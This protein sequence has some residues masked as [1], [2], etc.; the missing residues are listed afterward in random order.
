M[1][2]YWSITTARC[3]GPGVI[4]YSLIAPVTYSSALEMD[5]ERRVVVD[6]C[7][8]RAGLMGNPSVRLTAISRCVYRV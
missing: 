2:Q 1:G 3:T 8:A 5:F 7:F 6:E 4:T